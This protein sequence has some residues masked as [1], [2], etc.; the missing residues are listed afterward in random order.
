[1][2]PMKLNFE[3]LIAYLSRA[4]FQ[5]QDPRQA[6]NATRYSLSDAVLGAFSVFFIKK[7]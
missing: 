4:I 2:K 5:M 7:L 3:A 6:S 1:M